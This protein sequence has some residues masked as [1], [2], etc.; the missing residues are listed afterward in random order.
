[1][2]VP[3]TRRGVLLS[4]A[5]LGAAVLVG[6]IVTLE[7]AGEGWVVLSNREALIIESIAAVL[8]PPGIFPVHG[9]DGG[10]APAIDLLLQDFDA[11]V[12][13]S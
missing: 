12:P 10:T 13:P 8:F 2:G 4:G 3:I 5:L 9:G 6:R 7:P 11:S 1:M